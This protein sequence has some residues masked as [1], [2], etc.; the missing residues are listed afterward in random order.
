MLAF[1]RSL[2]SLSNPF[3]CLGFIQIN[4]FKRSQLNSKD[5][6]GKGPSCVIFRS[7]FSLPGARSLGLLYT[8]N[9]RE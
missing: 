7:G 9:G 5:R 6:H 1:G 2:L 8:V 4:P 3:F